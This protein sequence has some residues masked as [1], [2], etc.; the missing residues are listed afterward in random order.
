MELRRFL[1]HDES[2]FPKVYRSFRRAMNGERGIAGREFLESYITP[3][4]IGAEIGVHRGDFSAFLL[5]DLKVGKLHLIDPWKCFDDDKY[6]DALYGS[7]RSGGQRNMDLRFK[8]VA[9]R[10]KKHLD[11]GTA[12]V[13][14]ALSDAAAN[15]IAN[16]SLDW[17]YIDGDH[18]YEGIMADLTNYY[19]K[20]K[21]GGYLIGDDYDDTQWYAKDVI[22]ATNEFAEQPAIKAIEFKTSQFILQKLN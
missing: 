15:D 11:K 10:L 8:N 18:S 22:K 20:V 3:G 16:D 6:K 17:V 7:K 2:Y 12:V 13:H 9:S 21:V 19:P 1:R 14:R 5:N 4:S